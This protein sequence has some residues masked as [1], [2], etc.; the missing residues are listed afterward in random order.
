M[1]DAFAEALD[2]PRIDAG[3]LPTGALPY[4][5]LS[6]EF[7]RL[8]R[9]LPL[10]GEFAEHGFPLAMAN[11]LDDAAT[12]AV[13]LF[14]GRPVHRY[15]ALPTDIE[16]TLD[17]LFPQGA[18]DDAGGPNSE[19]VD[20]LTA[21][22]LG[23]SDLDRLREA[24]SAAPVIRLVNTLLGRAVDERGSDLHLEPTADSLTVRLRVDGQLRPS[25]PS[26]PARLRDANAC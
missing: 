25:E 7:L 18:A 20:N 19:T 15:V 6:P 4:E 10:P 9:V 13:A 16:S 26:V 24:A 17:R 8:M 23:T 5:G 11:P 12:E 21:P 22:G 2:L 3:S 1:A 14:V